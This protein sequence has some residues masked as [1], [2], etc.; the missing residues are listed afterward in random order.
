MTEIYLW[1][2]L[3]LMHL[4]GGYIM[5]A[6][7]EYHK[8]KYLAHRPALDVLVCFL[9]WELVTLMVIFDKTEPKENHHG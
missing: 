8:P 7:W 9:A 5:L 1:A 3:A 2:A 4:L 6:L